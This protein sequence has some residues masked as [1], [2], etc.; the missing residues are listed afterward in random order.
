MNSSGMPLLIFTVLKRHWDEKLITVRGVT[1]ENVQKQH[2]DYIACTRQ[3]YGSYFELNLLL[4]DSDTSASISTALP[5]FEIIYSVEIYN[6]F[7]YNFEQPSLLTNTKISL[8]T[9]RELES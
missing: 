3:A 2:T 7:V 4:S 1:H 5:V 8:E 6:G 9:F